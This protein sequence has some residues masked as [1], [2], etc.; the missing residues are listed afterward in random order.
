MRV[1]F[2][3]YQIKMSS[4]L[5]MEINKFVLRYLIAEILNR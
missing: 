2:Y 1:S 5:R 3:I 4:V